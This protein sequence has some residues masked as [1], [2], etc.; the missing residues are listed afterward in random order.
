MANY[1]DTVRPWSR[2]VQIPSTLAHVVG[3]LTTIFRLLYR[4]HLSKFWW[5]DTWAALALICDIACLASIWMETAPHN[6][7][8]P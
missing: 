7:E 8:F 5:E 3:I 6:R 4:W 1:F 2:T